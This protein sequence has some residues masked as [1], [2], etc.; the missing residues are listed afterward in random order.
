MRAKRTEQQVGGVIERAAAGR[1]GDVLEAVALRLE[2]EPAQVLPTLRLLADMDALAEPDD[3]R[4][5]VL[6]RQMNE[7]RVHAR[8]A[9]FRR[10]AHPTPVV[11]ELLGGVSRQAVSQR[12]EAGTLLAAEVGGR[13]YFPRWQFTAE[14]TVPGL[15][16]VLGPLTRAG[17]SP[18]AADALMR[19]PLPEEGGRSAAELLAAGK[20]DAAVHYVAIS[21]GGF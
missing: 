14:G 17:R 19:T 4:S 2:R 13:N 10:H 3:D 8:R 16:R 7:E 11:R 21:G 6:A 20:V 5:P 1:A 15:Q 12:V 9:E 18:I